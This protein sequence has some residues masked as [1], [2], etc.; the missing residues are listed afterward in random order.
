[1]S[2]SR[3][4]HPSERADQNASSYVC[5][6]CSTEWVRYAFAEAPETVQRAFRH[7][8]IRPA[9]FWSVR[10]DHHQEIETAIPLSA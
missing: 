6:R 2:L 10:H 4:C 3:C 7:R 8:D 9:H 5:P 1:M